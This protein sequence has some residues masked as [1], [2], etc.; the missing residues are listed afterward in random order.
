MPHTQRVVVAFVSLQQDG[1]QRA[2]KSNDRGLG[3]VPPLARGLGARVALGIT[4]IK[5]GDLCISPHSIPQHQ[6]VPTNLRAIPNMI[7]YPLPSV[8]VLEANGTMHMASK[9]VFPHRFNFVDFELVN[10][11]LLTSVRFKIA[12]SAIV[13]KWLLGRAGR[14]APIRHNGGDKGISISK[15]R[16]L[17]NITNKSLSMALYLGCRVLESCFNKMCTFLGAA[18][19]L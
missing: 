15:L 18:D 9:V 7:K 6:I 2:N 19:P 3:M 13:G 16:K 5:L 17:L 11:K 1:Q 8:E 4:S 10:C 14:P 12:Q